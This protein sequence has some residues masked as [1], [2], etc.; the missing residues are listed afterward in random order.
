MN[1]IMKKYKLGELVNVTRGTSLS[2]KYYS[3]KGKFIRL[4]LGNFNLNGGGFKQNT[5][6]TKDRKSVV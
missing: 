4:T 2:G 3:E 6:K 1:R 5:T